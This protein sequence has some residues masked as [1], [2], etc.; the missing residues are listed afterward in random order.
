M[1]GG[2]GK[3]E[4]P[5]RGAVELVLSDTERRGMSIGAGLD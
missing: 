4:G 2:L 1:F 5:L 3:D